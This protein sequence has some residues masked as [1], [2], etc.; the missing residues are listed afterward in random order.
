MHIPAAVT[1]YLTFSGKW[2]PFSKKWTFNAAF[3][4]EY[5]KIR[6]ISKRQIQYQCEETKKIV[7]LKWNLNERYQKM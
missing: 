4:G 2:I 3:T 7:D 6:V 1:R 5:K